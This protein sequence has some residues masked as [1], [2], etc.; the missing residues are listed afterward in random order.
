MQSSG[1]L[2]KPRPFYG[3]SVVAALLVFSTMAVGLAGPNVGLFIAPMSRELGW[4]P[5]T[6]GWAQ[7]ARME[8]VIIAGPVIGR[9]IDRYG[10]RVLVGVAALVTSGLVISLAFIHTEWHLMA[11]FVIT[12]LFGMGRVADVYVSPPV[13]RWFVRRRSRAMGIALAGTPIGI[14]VFYPLSQLLI[15][16][17]GWRDTWFVLGIAGLVVVVPLALAVLRRAPEDVGLLPDGDMPAFTEEAAA[18]AVAEPGHPWTRAQ[19]VRTPAF[20]LMVA[21]FSSFTFGWS[22][23]TIFRVPHFVERG[24]DPTLVAFAIAADAVVAVA[25]SVLLGW[26]LERIPPR[27]GMLFGLSGLA[28][29]GVGL[30]FVDNIPLLFIANIGYGFGFQTGHVA[31]NVMWA[32]YFGRANLG[33][34]RGLA[35]PLTVGLG[36]TA[37]PIVG[38]IR[39]A[40]GVYTPAWV[41]AIAGVALSAALLVNVR[42]PT[43]PHP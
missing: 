10:S 20:W 19:A 7:F 18:A 41:L 1:P 36:A 14:V 42:P 2:S 31:Q 6:F 21:G 9:L 23:F 24:L 29:C 28:V 43:P 22:T 37:F 35:L 34:I 13:A 40:A 15:D 11:V 16:R 17:I 12:G 8:A 38:A 33:S 3:W 27:F 25:A 39:D 5:L 32:S 26:R 4:S 30:I